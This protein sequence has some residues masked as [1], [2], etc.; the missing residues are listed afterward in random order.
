[1]R[2]L[3]QHFYSDGLR[4]DGQFYLP[5]DLP[6]GR[7]RPLVIVCSGFT[8]MYKIHP[9][10]FARWL[11]R[12]G[13][14]CF[15]FDYRGYGESEGP[16]FRVILEEQIRDIRN[17][18]AVAVA[19]K[20]VDTENVFLLGWAMGGGLVLDAARELEEVKGICAVNGLYDGPG[21]QRAHR[22]TEG[23]ATFRRRIRDE[24]FRRAATGI[25][26]YVDPFDIYPL[27]E[28]TRQYV[29]AS[30]APVEGYDAT[31]CSFELA[32]SLLRWSILPTAPELQLPLFLVHGDSNKLHPAEQ[33]VEL[34]AKYGGP[35]EIFWLE[36]AGHTEWMHDDHPLFTRLCDRLHG[37]FQQ[38][39]V[40]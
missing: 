17:A 39:I 36:D 9:E 4:L 14:L 15:G 34:R 24:R 25:A 31:L 12:H 8:G 40:S 16:R 3:P 11:T 6:S 19:S 35:V 30:L 21:F 22:G 37:W 1:V 10:R 38:Q 20:L 23:L 13:Y 28:V 32:E 2:K 5:D 29:R 18:V 7:H 33:A 26:Q 27:D